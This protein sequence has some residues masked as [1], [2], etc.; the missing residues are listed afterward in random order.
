MPPYVSPGLE[1]LLE[2]SFREE[3]RPTEAWPPTHTAVVCF[4]QSLYFL[5]V[6][7]YCLSLQDGSQPDADAVTNGTCAMLIWDEQWHAVSFAIHAVTNLMCHVTTSGE[8]KHPGDGHHHSSPRVWLSGPVSLDF[9]PCWREPLLGLLPLAPLSQPQ[10]LWTVVLSGFS[11]PRELGGQH[12]PVNC[13]KRHPFSTLS[14]VSVSLWQ[15]LYVLCVSSCVRHSFIEV[16]SNVLRM[17]LR[18]SNFFL[19]HT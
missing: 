15:S 16:H 18:I 7:S 2:K 9:V 1:G 19:A 13:S 4:S 10:Q 11:C 14:L 17:H 8:G 6:M 5:K 3:S 12:F